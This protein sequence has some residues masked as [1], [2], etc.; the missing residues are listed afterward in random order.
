MAKY[1]RRAEQGPT[2]IQSP[3]KKDTAKRREE[4]NA[5]GG[6]KLDKNLEAER[7]KAPQACDK[8]RRRPIQ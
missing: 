7:L 2:R 3:P 8:S 6:L 4:R 5:D 1:P